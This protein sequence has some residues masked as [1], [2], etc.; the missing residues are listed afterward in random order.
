MEAME[1]KFGSQ[2]QSGPAASTAFYDKDTIKILML[3]T[4]RI[5][6]RLVGKVIK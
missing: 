5:V 6:N 3:I 1:V 4:K 2:G